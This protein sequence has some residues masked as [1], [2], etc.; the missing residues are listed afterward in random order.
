MRM[1]FYIQGEVIYWQGKKN[2]KM[3]YIAKGTVQILSGNDSES[4]ILTLDTG[5]VIGEVCLLYDIRSPCQVRGESFR[6]SLINNLLSLKGNRYDI[7]YNL[8]FRKG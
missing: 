8:L 5:T 1:D 4:P 2:N 7:L 3:I 6:V